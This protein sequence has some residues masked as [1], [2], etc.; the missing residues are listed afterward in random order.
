LLTFVQT[1]PAALE[2]AEKLEQLR[3][4]ALGMRIKVV[5]VASAEIG[6]DTAEQ[7]DWARKKMKKMESHDETRW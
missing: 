1:K 4:M 5:H 6:I 3:A 2:M 7:L